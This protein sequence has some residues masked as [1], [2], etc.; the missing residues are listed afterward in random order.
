MLSLKHLRKMFSSLS[1][2]LLQS[3]R[4]G[5]EELV[6]R[7]MSLWGEIVGEQDGQNHNDTVAEDLQG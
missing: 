2:L 3:Q 1:V 5:S 4:H 7:H 6:N